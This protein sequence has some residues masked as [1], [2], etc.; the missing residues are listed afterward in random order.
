MADT[1]GTGVTEGWLAYVRGL[2]WLV[3]PG[4]S[5][6]PASAPP[7]ETVLTAAAAWARQGPV[8][9]GLFRKEP[10][11]VLVITGTAAAD[12]DYSRAI[13]ARLAAGFLQGEPDVPLPVRITLRGRQGS[14]ARDALALMRRHLGQA[15]LTLAD[16]NYL[17]APTLVTID[18]LDDLLPPGEALLGREELGLL[19]ELCSHELS[20]ARLAIVT[21]RQPDST[22]S[23][24]LIMD[25]LDEGTARITL[26]DAQPGRNRESPLTPYPGRPR[27]E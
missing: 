25:R 3:L 9:N 24:Q 20:Q 18:G 14:S 4:D 15:G 12:S 1:A 10:S 8:A 11:R 2:S 19:S 17:R 21:R 13:T 27:G 16:W 26:L 22:R 5:P 7:A 6:A 23:W